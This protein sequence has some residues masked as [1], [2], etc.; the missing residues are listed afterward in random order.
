MGPCETVIV[1]RC[2]HAGM[3]LG[4]VDV[5]AASAALDPAGIQAQRIHSLWQSTLWLCTAV[6]AAILLA[7][8]LALLRARSR[9]AREG[10]QPVGS[11]A[12]SPGTRTSVFVAAAVCSLLLAGLVAA[13]VWT[14]RALS[15]L[16]VANALHIEMTGVQWWWQARYPAEDGP[17]FAVANEL[18]VPVGRPVI[19]TLKS[20]DVIHSFWVP[21]L[22]GKKD[23]LPGRTT[24]IEFRADRAGTWRGEC[25]EFCGLQHALMAF[26]IT[27][28][29]SESYGQWRAQQQAPAAPVVGGE[30]LRGQS[31]F[32]ASRCAQ[33]HTVR[34]TSATGALG[35]DLTHVASRA[36]IAAGT[37]LNSPSN[38]AAWIVHPQGLKAGTTMP[39][40]PLQPDEVSALVAYLSSLE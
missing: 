16:P 15:R 32:M 25:A 17:A 34:G 39:D 7:L 40:S 28:E 6:F 20:V 33:C 13:D 38:L 8:V 36:T 2:L 5:A 24:T 11:R 1:R 18:H 23:M 31:L 12:H 19:V 3:A 4:A 27:A 22:H 26:S 37:V 35:P 9:A 14:D 21:E 30:A 10:A 29:A